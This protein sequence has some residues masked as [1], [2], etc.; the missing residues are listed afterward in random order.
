MVRQR[1]TGLAA[2]D[3]ASRDRC[4]RLRS[5]F[6]F[7][8]SGVFGPGGPENE[9]SPNRPAGFTAGF[10][11]AGISTC[12][13]EDAVGIIGEA[14]A[15]IGVSTGLTVLPVKNWPTRSVRRYRSPSVGGR[16]GDEALSG[17]ERPGSGYWLKLNGSRSSAIFVARM[18]PGTDASSRL[19]TELQRVAVIIAIPTAAKTAVRIAA[20]RIGCPLVSR[21]IYPIKS[22]SLSSF[23]HRGR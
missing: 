17:P 21:S 11:A 23:Q 2:L 3:A 18:A 5:F 15:S 9:R 12:P 6:C 20:F 4:G 14:P 16:V 19:L 8:G 1:Q 10:Q 13:G 22:S 7:R